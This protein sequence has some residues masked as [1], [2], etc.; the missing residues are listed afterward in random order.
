MIVLSGE[1]PSFSAETEWHLRQPSFF[2]VASAALWSCAS[3]NGAQA[4]PAANAITAI[5]FMLPPLILINWPQLAITE[6]SPPRAY[7]PLGQ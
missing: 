3:V 1:G 7:W 4:R 6:E 2:S 5:R